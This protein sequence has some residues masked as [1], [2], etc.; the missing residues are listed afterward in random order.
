[1]DAIIGFFN[2]IEYSEISVHVFIEFHD[3]SYIATSVAIIGSTPDSDNAFFI[4]PI[5]VAL[6]DQLMSS[7]DKFKIIVMVEFS[8]YY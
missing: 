2:G 3:S 4:E 7:C 1:M 8:C 5:I 6:L